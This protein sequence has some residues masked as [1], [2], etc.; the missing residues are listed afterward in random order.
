VFVGYNLKGGLRGRI[1]GLH[2]QQ[3][4]PTVLSLF[5]LVPPRDLAV[6]SILD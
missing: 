4:A 3:I 6:Q 2:I 1:D 5:G